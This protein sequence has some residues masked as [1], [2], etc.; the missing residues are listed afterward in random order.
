MIHTYVVEK[1]IGREID[2]YG[3][4]ERKLR[5]RVL[6]HFLVW[7]VFCAFIV[8]YVGGECHIMAAK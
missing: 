1:E 8:R 3:F 7:G 6:M 4:E 2:V 5:D